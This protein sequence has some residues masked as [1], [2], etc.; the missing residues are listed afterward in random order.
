MMQVEYDAIIEK[1]SLFTTVQYSYDNDL[2]IPFLIILRQNL[3][4]YI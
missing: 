4:I 1:L 3:Y 2:D